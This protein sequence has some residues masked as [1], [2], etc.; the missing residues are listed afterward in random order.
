M[1]QAEDLEDPTGPIN[2]R[3]KAFDSWNFL[4][5][6]PAG[7]YEMLSATRA[8]TPSLQHGGFGPA[9]NVE[10]DRDGLLLWLAGGDF[11]ANIA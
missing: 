5:V 4:T 11:G 8:A 7:V 3:T 6:S 10:C 2:P 9:R 1:Q